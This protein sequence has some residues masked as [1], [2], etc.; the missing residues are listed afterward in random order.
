MRGSKECL[1]GGRVVL[2]EGDLLD[3]HVLRAIGISLELVDIQHEHIALD[4]V[5]VSMYNIS[6]VAKNELT[7]IRQKLGVGSSLS[8]QKPELIAPVALPGLMKKRPSISNASNRC[9]PPHRRTSTSI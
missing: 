5:C 3:S 7:S 1:F 4:L 6:S 8:G 2:A 9:V